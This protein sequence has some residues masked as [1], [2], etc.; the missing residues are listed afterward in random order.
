MTPANFYGTKAT[1]LVGDAVHKANHLKKTAENVKQVLQ[2]SEFQETC[3][4][5]I[6]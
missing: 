2:Y 1:D 4:K 5:L 3:S 6:R